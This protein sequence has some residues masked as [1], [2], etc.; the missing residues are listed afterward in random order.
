[1]CTPL[2]PFAG[3]AGVV[4]NSEKYRR[5][6]RG[7]VLHNALAKLMQLGGIFGATMEYNFLGIEAGPQRGVALTGLI[8]ELVKLV[9]L[10]LR[11]RPTF[12]SRWLPLRDVGVIDWRGA[13]VARWVT[14]TP[15]VL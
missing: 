6:W 14:P 4:W 1:M 10:I 15:K 13:H 5:L 7:A 11:E 9:V 2:S 3:S 12:G 8:S